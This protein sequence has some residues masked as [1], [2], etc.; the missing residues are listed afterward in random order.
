MI[1]TFQLL[2]RCCQ[3]RSRRHDMARLLYAEGISLQGPHASLGLLYWLQPGSPLHVRCPQTQPSGLRASLPRYLLYLVTR[4]IAPMQWRYLLLAALFA[5]ELCL[6]LSPSSPSSPSAPTSLSARLVSVVFPQR[7]AHQ[8][9]LLLH[10]LF[11]FLSV[12]LS[13]VVPVLFPQ[14]TDPFRMDDARAYAP[15]VERMTAIARVADREGMSQPYFCSNT[16]L[17]CTL[18][19]QYR[20]CCRPSCTRCM[21]PR[22]AQ[23]ASVPRHFRL[24]HL[25]RVSRTRSRKRWRP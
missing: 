16:P 1:L 14:H 20:G 23:R 7:V 6:L 22:R 25:H 3:I 24:A 10:Q 19:T 4:V 8:H 17:T 18:S 11:V 2:T 9:I 21:G 5:S 15:L 13:R 12:A